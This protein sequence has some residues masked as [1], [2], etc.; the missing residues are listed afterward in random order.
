MR[1][2]IL[3]YN[4]VYVQLKLRTNLLYVVYL[5]S[6]R[7]DPLFGSNLVIWHELFISHPE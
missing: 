4:Q 6:V 1:E 7:E 2:Y 5:D 3:Y